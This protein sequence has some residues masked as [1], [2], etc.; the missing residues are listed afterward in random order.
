VGR[1]S[2]QLGKRQASVEHTRESILRAARD[3]VV[4]GREVS[5]GRV[6]EAAGVSRITVY[7]QFGSKAGLLQALRPAAPTAE[8]SVVDARDELRQRISL[9]CWTWASHSSLLR[10]LP[11]TYEEESQTNRQLAERL[12]AAD[13]LRPGCSIKEAE[14]V[15]GALTSFD[16]F[17]R[18]YRDGRRSPGAV[19]EILI[20][21]A[22]GILA[23]K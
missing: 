3:A 1:R 14:D 10:H 8:P 21:L 12:A 16:L 13:A 18:L 4:A 11:R 5:V 19:A 2:Y 20:R 7:N 17:D 9:A 23:D 22:C 15:I 6:A